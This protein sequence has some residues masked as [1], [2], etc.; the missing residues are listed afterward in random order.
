MPKLYRRAPRPSRP[1]PVSAAERCAHCGSDRVV[2]PLQMYID[3]NNHYPVPGLA[4]ALL[5]IEIH[6]GKLAP[7]AFCTKCFCITSDLTGC[8]HG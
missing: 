8:A 4:G 5:E 6:Q 2:A 7:V 3:L 1:S